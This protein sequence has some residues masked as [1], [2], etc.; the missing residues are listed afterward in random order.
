[1]KNMVVI[2][3]SV[4]FLS[5]SLTVS[6]IL[7]MKRNGGRDLDTTSEQR[8]R[9]FILVLIDFSYTTSYRFSIVNYAIGRTV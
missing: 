6:E 5:Q 2:K 7:K 8:S 3:L 9:S 4:K 1:M